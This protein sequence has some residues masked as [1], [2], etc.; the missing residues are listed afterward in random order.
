VSFDHIGVIS[1]RLEDV[2]DSAFEVL[3]LLAD[4]VVVASVF[5]LHFV[6]FVLVARVFEVLNFDVKVVLIADVGDGVGDFDDADCARRLVVDDVV[7]G[8]VVGV[9]ECELGEAFDGVFEADEWFA[10]F[11][12]A[13]DGDGVAGDGLGGESVGDGAEVVVEVEACVEAVVR[14]GLF[15]LGAVDDGGADVADGDVELLVGQPHVC[16]VVAFGE[17][18][19]AAGHRGEWDF[20]AFVLVFHGGAA[21]G[22]GEFGGA[23]D[24]G[25]GGFDEVGVGEV[26]FFEAPEEIAGSLEVVVLGVVRAFAVNLGV[27]GRRLGGGVDD[28]VRLVDLEEFVD[29]VFVGEVAFDEREVCEAVGLFGGFESGFDWLDGG[30]GG[31]ADFVDPFAAGEVVDEEDAVV[32]VGGDAEAGWPADVAVG[33][34][35]EDGHSY[36]IYELLCKAKKSIG[37]NPRSHTLIDKLNQ[38]TNLP[39]PLYCNH[40]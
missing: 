31:G 34:S 28:G 36:S 16:G 24:A 29:E 2:L 12:F 21:F 1:K 38:K 25:G 9:G 3:G 11:A 33:A 4:E 39:E 14:S 15:G 26:V 23:V 8:S 7:V 22:D 27:G 6:G 5:D 18:V 17:V 19:P 30:G 35:N 20:V 32:G 37:Y 10:L 13:V 40:Y